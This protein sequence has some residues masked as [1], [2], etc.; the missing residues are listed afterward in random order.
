MNGFKK[1]VVADRQ[2]VIDLAIQEYGCY[3]GVW[4]LLKDNPAKLLGVSDVPAAGMQLLIRNPVPRLTDTNL[5]VVNA[6]KEL[7]HTVVSGAE[8][9]ENDNLL[10]WEKDYA[11]NEYTQG[12]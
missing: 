10:Y 12:G 1:I 5:E 3:E 8:A 6:Y 4:L 11:E 7:K 2:C 9:V